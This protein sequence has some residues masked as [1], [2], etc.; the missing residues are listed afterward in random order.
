M[1]TPSTRR[2]RGAQASHVHVISV[3]PTTERRMEPW[4]FHL[5]DVARPARTMI[6][7]AE[8]S[9]RGRE[10]CVWRM[11]EEV[12]SMLRG[13]RSGHGRTRAIVRRAAKGDAGGRGCIA[14]ECRNGDL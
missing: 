7:S 1:L 13:R 2:R 3:A 4:D 5:G 8:S 14:V 9:R 10:R 11:I 6:R 12:R